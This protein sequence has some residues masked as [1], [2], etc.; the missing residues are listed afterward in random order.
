MNSP[1][2]LLF[3]LLLLLAGCTTSQ[4]GG[5]RPLIGVAFLVHGGFEEYSSNALWDSTLQIFS[6]DPNSF[7]YQRVIW[8]EAAWPMVLRVGNA[9]KEIGK[10]S[11]ELE[12]IGGHDPAMDYTRGQ[13]EDLTTALAEAEDSLDVRFITDYI[14]WIGDIDHLASPRKIYTPQTKDGSQVRYCGNPAEPWPNC[15]PERYNTDGT[16]DRFLQAGVDEIIVIDLTTSG[17][18]FFKS[19]DVIR[20]SREIITEHNETHSTQVTLSWLNDPTDLMQESYPDQPAGWTNS[21][22]KPDN[23]PLVPLAGRPNPVS[24]D[25][26]FASLQAVGIKQQMSPDIPAS[27]TGVMLINHATRAHNQ[28]FDPKID[29]TLVLNANIRDQLLASM[30]GLNADMI[31]GSWMGIKEHNP[32]IKPR[33]PS[34]S[35]YERTRKMRGENLGHAYLYETDEEFP[36]AEWGFLYWDALAYLKDQGAQH[37]VVAF[38]QITVDSVLNQV[39]LPNQIAKE[40]GY[41][42]WLYIDKPDYDTYPDVGHPFADY[43]GI[44]IRQQCPVAGTKQTTECCFEMGGCSDGH[45]YPPPRLAAK[46]KSRNDLD[47]SLA[48]DVSAYGHL[49]YNPALGSPD[50]T[51]AVQQQYRGS[52]SIWTPPNDDP[53]V[54]SFLA[55]HVIDYLRQTR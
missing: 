13:L 2:R 42:N 36:D 9:P 37:I 23:D 52:W 12:R 33:P 54:G 20:L 22:G 41:R 30:P 16:I 28:L 40:I 50:P 45:V 19:N 14:N 51:Q 43:W 5:R 44:W 53:R 27:K 32:D 29:D 31:V 26:V 17:V 25:P 4:D 15:S 38:P 1:A 6:Y 39:E 49:G 48:Y 11:F 24:S 10:Y 46:D 34:F 21:L 18:R 7:V 47:P 3:I 8:N 35:T 55:G